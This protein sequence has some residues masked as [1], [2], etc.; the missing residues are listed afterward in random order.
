MNK[1]SVQ[2]GEY[3]ITKLSETEYEYAN[4]K[5]ELDFHFAIEEPNE[6]AV[7]VFD[8]LISEDNEKAFLGAFFASNLQEAI[9]DVAQLTKNSVKNSIIWS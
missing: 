1:N 6:V 9:S 2:I 7:Y 4:T 8:S 3:L 5:Q